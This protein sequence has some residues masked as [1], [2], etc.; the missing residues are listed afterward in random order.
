M[1]ITPQE[2]MNLQSGISA[3]DVLI[4]KLRDELE[5]TKADRDVWKE[6][7]QAA[8]AAERAACAEEGACAEGHR[9]EG[10][11]VLSVALLKSILAK[12]HNLHILAVIALVLQRALH[13]GASAEERCSISELVPLPELPS[14]SL[15]A[16]G[17]IDVKG[18]WMDIHDNGN[19]KL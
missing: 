12:I 4:A 6:R 2:F 3:K 15:T 7:A 1:E 5:Q 9:K 13:R 17:D 11:V 18:D 14:I 16:N 10:V 8:C 19:V